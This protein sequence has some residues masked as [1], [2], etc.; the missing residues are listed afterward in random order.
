MPVDFCCNKRLLLTMYA[1]LCLTLFLFSLGQASKQKSYMDGQ[2]LALVNH[3]V[4]AVKYHFKFKYNDTEERTLLAVIS[5]KQL[6][7]IRQSIYLVLELE[8]TIKVE[9][10]KLEMGRGPLTSVN[11]YVVTKIVCHTIGMAV[12]KLNEEEQRA[13][14]FAASTIKHHLRISYHL[15]PI[16]VY[17]VSSKENVYFTKYHFEQVQLAFANCSKN[18][19]EVDMPRSNCSLSIPAKIVVF[20]FDT[21]EKFGDPMSLRLMRVQK[22]SWP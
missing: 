9:R 4:E 1:V 8:T 12:G 21:M 13:L 16:V 10:C 14:H 2:R 3:A 19:H 17:M 22:I 7:K 20:N 5:L 6:G 15:I 11:P 18:N